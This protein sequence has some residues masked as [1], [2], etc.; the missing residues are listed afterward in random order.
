[1]KSI[2]T[3]IRDA[4][5]PAQTRSMG[6]AVA[7]MPRI[8]GAAAAPRSGIHAVAAASTRAA[9]RTRNRLPTAASFPQE[10]HLT[11]PSA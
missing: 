2:A 11:R 7:T 5:P 6:S 1:M 10:T 3:Y 4:Q 8:C 9:D